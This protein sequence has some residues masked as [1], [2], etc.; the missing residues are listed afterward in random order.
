MVTGPPV[1]VGAVGAAQPGLG[2]S[3]KFHATPEERTKLMDAGAVELAGTV[4]ENGLSSG[5]AVGPGL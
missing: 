5:L 3:V 4:I 2:T 1:Q